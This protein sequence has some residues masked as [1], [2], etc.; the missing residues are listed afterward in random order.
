MKSR[1]TEQLLNCTAYSPA[2]LFQSIL[3]SITGDEEKRKVRIDFFQT[4]MKDPQ[5]L[6]PIVVTSSPPFLL[7]LALAFFDN[8][9]T[10]YEGSVMT[11]TVETI[12]SI[13]VSFLTTSLL[14]NT[15]IAERDE[16]LAASTMYASNVE[17]REYR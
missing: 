10:A 3:A 7:A 17:P 8:G 14:F 16:I 13:V 5:K 12:V 15:V 2:P 6:T 4:F 11:N 1:L 9:A